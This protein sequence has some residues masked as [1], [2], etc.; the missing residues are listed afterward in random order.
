M[1]RAVH[2]VTFLTIGQAPRPDLSDAI[3][4]HLPA[5]ARIRHAGVLDGLTRQ[6]AE[7]TFGATEGGATLLS[8]LADGGPV[9]L[10]ADAIG[11]GLQSRIDQEEE[12]GA[13]V[14][15]LLCTGE[16]PGLRTRR[17]RLVEPDALVTGYVGT[18]LRGSRVGFVVPLPEQ[19]TE[20][21]TK[22]RAVVPDPAFTTASPYA[23]NEAALLSAACTHLEAGADA[24]MLDCMGYG[25]RHR[26][27]LRAAGLTVPIL[28][29][30]AVVGAAL[31]PLLA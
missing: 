26:R 8:R 12:A 21:R 3:E 22:W 25:E 19:V 31:G 23:D 28:T 9:T 7:R 1:R 10:D 11:A 27:S 14:V 24:L 5:T 2:T 20:A 15:V 6:E 18:V 17:A 30:G 16:F 29:P 4:A 13:D